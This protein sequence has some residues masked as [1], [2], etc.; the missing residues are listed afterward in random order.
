MNKL[1]AKRFVRALSAAQELLARE[2]KCYCYENDKEYLEVKESIK[3]SIRMLEESEIFAGKLLYKNARNIS[4]TTGLSLARI[5]KTDEE[6]NFFTY[7]A[8]MN[9]QREQQAYIREEAKLYKRG[10]RRGEING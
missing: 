8:D 6:Q 5:A 3:F 9:L 1:S 10:K 2:A 7:V 4:Y